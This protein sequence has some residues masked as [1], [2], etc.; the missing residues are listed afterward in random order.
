VKRSTSQ[1]DRGCHWQILFNNGQSTAS[2]HNWVENN[3]D[4][5]LPPPAQISPGY[6]RHADWADAESDDDN[7]KALQAS[8]RAKLTRR[9]DASARAARSRSPSNRGTSTG[10]SS[11]MVGGLRAPPAV[12]RSF[13]HANRRTIIKD[14][15]NLTFA[16]NAKRQVPLVF[17]RRADT[18]TPT[19]IWQHGNVEYYLGSIL[20]IAQ[21]SCTGAANYTCIIDCMGDVFR[22]PWDPDALNTTAVLECAWNHAPKRVEYLVGVLT[23]VKSHI[24]QAGGKQKIYV[25][26]RKGERRSAAVVAVMLMV[27]HDFSINAA[28]SQITDRRPAAALTCQI[29]SGYEASYGLVRDIVPQ[30]LEAME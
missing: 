16:K 1:A 23:W 9:S 14:A 8:G 28:S 18:Y 10:A 4:E 24:L 17:P 6:D 11:S 26:C 21:D 2:R 19:L 25:C 3:R 5:I 13:D 22:R 20:D 27:L 7:D 30:V 29:D 15:N 12:P